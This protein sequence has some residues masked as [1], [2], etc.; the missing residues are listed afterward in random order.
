MLRGPGSRVPLEYFGISGLESHFGCLGSG[1]SPRPIGSRGP[2]LEVPSHGSHF[3]SM[4]LKILS[5]I[6]LRNHKAW[7]EI[8]FLVLSFQI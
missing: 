7:L 8:Y 5:K 3:S 1:V 4:P 2:P 6:I